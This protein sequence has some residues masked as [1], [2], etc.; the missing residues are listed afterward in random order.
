MK[1]W[2]IFAIACFSLTV[3]GCEAPAPEKEEGKPP[4]PLSTVQSLV[5]KSGSEVFRS[6]AL[7]K[8]GKSCNSCHPDGEGLAGVGKKLSYD[9]DLEKMVNKCITGPLK[10]EALSFDSPVMVALTSY[11]RTL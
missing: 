8:S 11:L 6:T 1:K 10:G 5:G 2:G 4:A 3:L 7:G 9:L